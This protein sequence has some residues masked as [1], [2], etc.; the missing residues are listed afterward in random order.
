MSAPENFNDVAKLA[1]LQ[2]Q[3]TTVTTTLA[4]TEDD[5]TEKSLALENFA[6]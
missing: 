4:Q 2:T 6:D 5:W 1:D 3:L